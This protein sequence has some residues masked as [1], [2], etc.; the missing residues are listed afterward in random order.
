M[1]FLTK[2]PM[3]LL[4]PCCAALVWIIGRRRLAAGPIRMFWWI[5]VPLTL[6]IGLSWFFVLTHRYPE[7]WD[8]FTRYELTQRIASGVHRRSKPFWYHL[9]MLSVGLLPWTVF[10]PGLLVRSWRRLRSG[11][12]QAYLFLGWIAVPLIVLSL[13]QSKLATYILPLIPPL[14]ILLVRW[15]EQA[16][17]NR[18]WRWTVTLLSLT[19]ILALAAGPFAM[20]RIE[21]HY[22]TPIELSPWFAVGIAITLG[23]FI[24]A[25]VLAWR[26]RGIAWVLPCLCRATSWRSRGTAHHL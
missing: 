15:W 25:P 23:L 10:L 19:L 20:A 6:A 5:G 17:G 11:D 22:S 2:G 26:P 12:T 14:A 8:Y 3:A 24:T 16:A 9:V 4:V 13:V 21:A 1:G 18:A 7:L